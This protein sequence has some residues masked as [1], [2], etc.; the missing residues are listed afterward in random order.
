MKITD[1][2]IYTTNEEKKLLDKLQKPC[3]FET[4]SEREQHVSENLVRK[5]LLRKIRYK[6]STVVLPNEKP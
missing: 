1:L 6:G 2:E 5:S 4:L 3:Y